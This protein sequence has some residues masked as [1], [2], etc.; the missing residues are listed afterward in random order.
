[1]SD[2]GGGSQENT[3]DHSLL[4]PRDYTFLRK[5]CVMLTEKMLINREL[6][7]EHFCRLWSDRNS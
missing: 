5:Y 2:N 1:M 4:P 6:R 3:R 7:P